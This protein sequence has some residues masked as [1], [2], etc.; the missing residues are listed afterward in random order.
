MELDVRNEW[1]YVARFNPFTSKSRGV[2][3]NLFNNNFNF[4]Y[5]NKS[6]QRIQ[7]IYQNKV[8]NNKNVSLFSLYGPNEG[9]EDTQI[10]YQDLSN[11]SQN[12]KADMN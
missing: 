6:Q 11:M 9:K 10:F 12:F 1:G 3:V 2:A 7:G 5:M 4:K 8:I